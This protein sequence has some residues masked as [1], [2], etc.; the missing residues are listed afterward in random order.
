MRTKKRIML[1]VMIVELAILDHTNARSNIIE[2]IRKRIMLYV[3]LF[4]DE[5]V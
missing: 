2:F 5:F 3:V 4:I 1:K